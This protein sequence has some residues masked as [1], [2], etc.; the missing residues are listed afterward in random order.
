MSTAA[1]SQVETAEIKAFLEKGVDIKPSHTSF[2]PL[3]VKCVLTYLLT[4][5]CNH[6]VAKLSLCSLTSVFPFYAQN[7]GGVAIR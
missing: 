7:T 6:T 4:I 1:F 5:A 3:H 2:P